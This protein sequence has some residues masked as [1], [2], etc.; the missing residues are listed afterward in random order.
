M[1]KECLAI[2]WFI[3]LLR[4]FLEGWKVTARAD[5]GAFINKLNIKNDTGKLV[6]WLL[7]ISDLEFKFVHRLGVNHLESDFLS[8]LPTTEAEESPL[9]DNIPVL[10]ISQAQLE[11]LN[12]K[13][14]QKNWDGR[15]CNDGDDT[16]RSQN[17]G[18]SRLY[19]YQTDLTENDSLRQA[20]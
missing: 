17:M 3:I 7:S 8:S 11:S 18:N 15:P 13:G 12:I 4:M 9:K 2:E 1:P 6:R 14:R 5:H 20:N 19:R 16:T 10:T